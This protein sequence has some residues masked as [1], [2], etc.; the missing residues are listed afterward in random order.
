MLRPNLQ[1]TR[2]ITAPLGERLAGNTEDEIEVEIRDARFAQVAR[3]AR[4]VRRIMPTF[5]RL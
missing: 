3:R 2:E 5:E 4:N 1:C